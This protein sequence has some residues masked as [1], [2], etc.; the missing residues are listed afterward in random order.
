MEEFLSELGNLLE[1]PI[2]TR[3][4][5]SQDER[6]ALATTAEEELPSTEQTIH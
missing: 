3:S 1:S 6:T 4:Y 2:T 5:V